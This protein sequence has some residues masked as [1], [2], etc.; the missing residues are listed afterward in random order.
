MDERFEKARGYDLKAQLRNH[1]VFLKEIR[2]SPWK[3]FAICAVFAGLA[4]L[5]LTIEPTGSAK[6][7]TPLRLRIVGVLA[8]VVSG[9]FALQGTL[10]LLTKE[11]PSTSP[12]CPTSSAAIPGAYSGPRPRAK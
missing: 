2:Q 11:Y 6:F 3:A 10:G 9:Y 12:D 7:P 5:L 4:L 8:A 1:R